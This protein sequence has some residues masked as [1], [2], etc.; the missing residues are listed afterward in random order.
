MRLIYDNTA[1]KA[2]VKRVLSEQ[3]TETGQKISFNAKI[4]GQISLENDKVTKLYV[5]PTYANTYENIMAFTKERDRPG[6][7]LI[8][9][10]PQLGKYEILNTVLRDRLVPTQQVCIVAPH[11]FTVE[12]KEFLQTYH[13]PYFSMRAI[14][15][16]G[17]H[18]IIQK[19]QQVVNQWTDCM[20]IIDSAALDYPIIRTN[21]SGGLTTRQLLT[22]IQHVKQTSKFR[23][24]ELII[25]H[26]EPRVAV[27]LITE[28]YQD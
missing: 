6:I 1:Y 7:L 2:I 28:M 26:K 10:K 3:I 23:E 15:S 14:A 8:S 21:L 5:H 13:V 19:V 11:I 22:I 4:K 18:A 12:E 20:I 24:S 16:E 25:T 17:V 9:S 27:K